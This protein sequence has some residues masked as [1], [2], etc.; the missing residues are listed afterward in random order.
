[1]MTFGRFIFGIIGI[2]AGLLIL[3]C[4]EKIRDFFG[5]IDFA[6]KVFGSGGTW[7]FITLL[8][9]IVPIFSVMWMFGSFQS[10]VT[11]HFAQFF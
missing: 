3:K 5:D 11:T 9:L 6:E 7:T 10:F 2:V 1:M 4:R 8:G